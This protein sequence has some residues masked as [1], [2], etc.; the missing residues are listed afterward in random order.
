MAFVGQDDDL[1]ALLPKQAQDVE[2]EWRGYIREREKKKER[3]RTN[4][5][6]TMACVSLAQ[7]HFRD[8]EENKEEGEGV[9]PRLFQE[10]TY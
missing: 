7:V 6:R 1:T 3:E 10:I 5:T 2:R 8:E 4:G 9:S